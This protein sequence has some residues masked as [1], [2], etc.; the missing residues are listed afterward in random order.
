MLLLHEFKLVKISK[1]NNKKQQ[2]TTFYKYKSL[3]NFE[4]LLD[5]LLKE[6]LYAAN[7]HELNDPMEGVIKIDNTVTKNKESEWESILNYLR[8][9]C[10]TK[11]PNNLLMW[12][13]YA[14]GTKG[15][16]IE[17]ELLE[18]QEVYRIEYKN[19]P[20][21]SADKINL[22]GAYEILTYKQKPWKYEAE[23][24]CILDSDKFLPIKI[25]SVTFGAR[26]NDESIKLLMDILSLCK[27]ELKVR[28]LKKLGSPLFAGH[29]FYVS[30]TRIY[31]KANE[32]E[33]QK[34]LNIEAAQRGFRYS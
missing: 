34:C 28:K 17:F 23:Y 24:R 30:S 2:T 9:V 7:Y 22:K 31:I 26:A 3:D 33:C 14:N 18:N 12:S 19:K 6:R 5:L 11:D 29:E 21:V 4:F 20:T 10:F 1:M 27:P 13:H 25:K 32:G 8:V 15:C 16:V